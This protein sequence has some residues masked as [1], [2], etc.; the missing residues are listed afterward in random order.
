MRRTAGTAAPL[1]AALLLAALAAGLAGPAPAQTAPPGAPAAAP[2][3]PGAEQGAPVGT[4]G[5]PVVAQ[6][7]PLVAEACLGCHGPGGAG[8]N[9]V[10]ALAGRSKAELVAAI[11]AFRA[12]ERPATIMNRIARGYSEAEMAAALD[13]FAG[14]H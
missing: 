7:A 3:A 4:Q 1:R 13:H 2:G 9:G 8:G 10:P 5:V 12:N 6:G 14:E 11:A